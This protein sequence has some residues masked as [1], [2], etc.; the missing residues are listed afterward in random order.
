[1]WK[2]ELLCNPVIALLGIYPKHRDVVK[3]RG[4]CTPMFLAALAPVAK[5]WKE[6]RGPLTDKWMKMWS[7]YTMEYYS[8]I[9][10]DEHPLF[11]STRMEP[12]EIMLNERS[13]AEKAKYHVVS[14][15]CR[16]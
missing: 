16:T 5:L 9:R 12:E 1:M 3:R 11:A 14:L 6:P 13:Q 10:K 15:V 8:V 4:T 2:I 7:I